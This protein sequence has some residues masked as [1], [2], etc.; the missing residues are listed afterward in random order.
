MFK[1][2]ALEAK[3]IVDATLD[4]LLAWAPTRGRPGSDLRMAVGSTKVYAI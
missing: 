2:D 1:P 3:P 4:A